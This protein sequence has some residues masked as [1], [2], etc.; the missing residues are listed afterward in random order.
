MLARKVIGS[1]P[2]SGA[3]FSRPASSFKEA[4]DEGKQR[5]C[6]SSCER[7]RP[8]TDPL[9][10]LDLTSIT[11]QEIA[12]LLAHNMPPADEDH[13]YQYAIIPASLEMPPGK[14]SAQTGHAFGD[15]FSVAVAMDPV[16]AARYR[17]LAHGGSKVTL[18]A[19]NQHQLVKAFAQARELG[20]PCALVV[21]R[22]H[23]LPPHF[24]GSPIL[25]ALGIGPCT[26]EEARAVTKKF[27]CL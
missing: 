16:R 27:Q 25:T 18:K 13:L 5:T 1:N 12:H 10:K 14:L 15:S 4:Q 20:I 26:K 6:C 23:I 24:D 22:H 2:I 8:L 21:D 11:P 19:K 3:K 7:I 17:D 9:H